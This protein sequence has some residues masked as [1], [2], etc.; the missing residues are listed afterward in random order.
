MP[1]KLLSDALRPLEP[2]SLWDGHEHNHER[3]KFT[4]HTQRHFVTSRQSTILPQCLTQHTA[5]DEWAAA[6]AALVRAIGVPHH[7][8]AV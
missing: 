3:L 8:T 5:L 4:H 1:L 2:I 6:E 7:I